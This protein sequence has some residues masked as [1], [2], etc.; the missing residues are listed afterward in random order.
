LSVEPI[1]KFTLL[2]KVA[3]QYSKL[4]NII[5]SKDLEIDRSLNSE[6]FQTDTAFV[7]PSWD[8]LISYMHTDYIKYYK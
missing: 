6:R 1:D 3:I 5:D 4:I 7:V 2:N 8:T